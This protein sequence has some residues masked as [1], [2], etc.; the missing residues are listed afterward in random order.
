MPKNNIS[1]RR[2]LLKLSGE[3][4]AG[5]A[6]HAIDPQ[7]CRAIAGQIAEIRKR[8]VQTGIVIGGGNIMRGAEA[9]AMDRVAAD[10]AGMLATVIN[11]LALADF[12]EQAGCPCRVLTAHAL[13]R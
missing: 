12:L 9:S 11:S 3:A 2:I 10:T 8:G 1:Y 13:G 4:L 6:G 7:V 5:S